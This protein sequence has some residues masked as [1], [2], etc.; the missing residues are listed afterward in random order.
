MKKM[1]VGVLIG[2]SLSAS[3]A[4]AAAAYTAAEVAAHGS[5][6][7]CWTIVSGKVYN[8]TSYIPFHPGGPGAIIGLC[9]HDGTAAFSGIHSGSGSANSMLASLYV[10]DLLVP[11]TAAPSVPA[12]LAAA[13]VST[14]QI[15]LSWTASTDNVEVSGYKIYRGGAQIA[16][17]TAPVY[18]N[19]GLTASTTY[20]YQFSAFD[21]AG[22]V[23]G[24]S[25]L[26]GATTLPAPI[27]PPNPLPG[28]I[29]TST[30]PWWPHHR[31]GQG[32]REQDD[33]DDDNDHRLGNRP[34]R[35][36][37]YGHI[38]AAEKIRLKYNKKLTL[39]NAQLQRRLVRANR[40]RPVQAKKD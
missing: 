6:T 38:S 19:I 30:P 18:N 27:I 8:L 39:L 12:G 32:K 5:S 25:N 7:D 15:N 23:S 34:G 31:P 20:N 1:I 9:G 36:I 4:V 24:L 33:H 29:A 13:A 22:N 26:A 35:G 21:A 16:T 37:G 11:D 17:T 3:S 10:G 14:S 28:P 40:A 2:F